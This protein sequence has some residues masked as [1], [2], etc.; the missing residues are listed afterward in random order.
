[1]KITIKVAIG[2]RKTI[3][4]WAKIRW[5]QIFIYFQL[6]LQLYS[7]SFIFFYFLLLTPLLHFYVVIHFHLKI[8]LINSTQ[9]LHLVYSYNQLIINLFILDAFLF[10]LSFIYLIILFNYS[11]GFSRLFLYQRSKICDALWSFHWMWR[12]RFSLKLIN[13]LAFCMT[14]SRFSY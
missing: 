5:I 7:V 3:G 12:L 4:Q 14:A 2:I 1:M 11:F 8:T 9:L 6:V 13:C 10:I